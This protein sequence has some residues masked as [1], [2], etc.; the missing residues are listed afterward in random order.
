[1]GNEG[2]LFNP[3]LQEIHTYI[4]QG[5]YFLEPE[6]TLRLF[7]DHS[8]LWSGFGPTQISG[9]FASPGSETKSPE[10]LNLSR[11]TPQWSVKDLI[12]LNR[13]SFWMIS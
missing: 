6:A 10:V 9:F 2:F 11:I 3:R 5:P 12:L 8:R 13:S 4:K 7:P 1:M